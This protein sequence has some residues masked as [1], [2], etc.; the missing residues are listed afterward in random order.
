MHVISLANLAI[1]FFLFLVEAVSGGV[2]STTILRFTM[3]TKAVDVAYLQSLSGVSERPN[4]DRKNR[5][6]GPVF[7]VK[8]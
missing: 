3:I 2:T 4:I 7:H 1:L 8:I 5:P 6:I